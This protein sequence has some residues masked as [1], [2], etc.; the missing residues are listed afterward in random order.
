VCHEICLLSTLAGGGRAETTGVSAEDEEPAEQ[1]QGAAAEGHN[2]NGDGSSDPTNNVQDVRD[3]VDLPAS[4]FDSFDSALAA[5]RGKYQ[6][7]EVDFRLRT[8]RGSFSSYT[9]PELLMFIS[10]VQ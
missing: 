8:N 10:L 2:T 3:V 1:G 4:M 7:G 6:C 5:I 9:C